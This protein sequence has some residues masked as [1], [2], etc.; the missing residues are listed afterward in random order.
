MKLYN[1]LLNFYIKPYWIIKTKIWVFIPTY[2][3]GYSLKSN[4][5]SFKPICVECK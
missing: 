4:N 5:D 2:K 3:I 1:S